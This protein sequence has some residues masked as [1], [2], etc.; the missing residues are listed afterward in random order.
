MKATNKVIAEIKNLYKAKGL[1]SVH[2]YIKRYNIECKI[3][4]HEFG[5][6][7]GAADAKYNFLHDKTSNRIFR[8]HYYSLLKRAKNGYHVNLLRGIEFEV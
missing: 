1:N 2:A 7:K 5:F 8:T 3:Y 6:G 4:Q